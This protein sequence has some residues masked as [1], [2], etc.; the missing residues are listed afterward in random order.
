MRISKPTIDDVARVAG[1]SRATA[2]RVLNDAP[3][4]SGPVRARVHDA[5]AALGYRPNETA[6]ALASGRQRTVDVLAITYGPNEGWLGGHPYY[7]RVLAGMMSVLEAVDVQLR[8]CAVGSDATPAAIDAIAANATAGAVLATVTPTMAAR[9]HRRC[10]RAVSLVATAPSVPAIEADNV[11]GAYTAVQRLHA[12]GRG[13]IAAIHGPAGN[14]CAIDRRTGYRRAMRQLGLPDISAD[15]DFLRAGG[16]QAALR[17]LDRHPD[18]DA[19]FVA[20]DLMAAGAVQA[21]AATGRR[22]PDDVSIVG[23][24]DSVAAICAN[25][26]LSTMRLPVEEMAAAATRLLLAGTVPTG[27]RERFAVD[28][29]ERGSTPRSTA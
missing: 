17:L 23:F 6:R 26:P 25:P 21:I 13:R 8:L 20:C 9:F 11:G 5:V 16:Y 28:F 14:P 10:R 4:A 19:M 27:H 1:V 18:L 2:S 12:R 24:D 3:G 15:G 7:S 29:V 22:V